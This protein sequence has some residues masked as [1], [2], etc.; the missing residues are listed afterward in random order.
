MASMRKLCPNRPL[1][2]QELDLPA[3]RRV[4]E[5]LDELAGTETVSY[6]HPSKRWEYPWALE[7]ASLG[8]GSKVLDA[9]CG[10]SIFPIYLA[11]IGHRV[12]ACD[13]SPP[14]RL[15]RLH[16]ASVGYA[17]ADLTALPFEDRVFDTVFCIS[18]IE[19]LSEERMPAALQELRRVL[20]DG[21]GLLLT[22]DYYE[23]ARAEVWYESSD[24]RFRVDWSFFD[25]PKLRRVVIEAPGF[26]IEGDLTIEVDWSTVSPQMRRF[27]GYP[28]TSVGVKLIRS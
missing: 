3:Y 6:L 21:G 26:R 17:C 18:V 5:R 2:L 24:R 7:R 9:G 12:T 8:K 25:E 19:H 20:R 13:I 11:E 4:I 16:G 22:T 10:G 1:N 28:Y 23:D 14:P 27:H 15:D